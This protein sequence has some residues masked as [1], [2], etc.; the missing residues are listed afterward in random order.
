MAHKLKLF[1]GN[2]NWEFKKTYV[3]KSFCKH[4]L[5][6]DHFFGTPFN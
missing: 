6:N 5:F 2:T 4:L 1:F 3:K